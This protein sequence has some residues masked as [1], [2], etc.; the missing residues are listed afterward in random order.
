MGATGLA[1][2]TVLG[3]GRDGEQNVQEM[4]GNRPP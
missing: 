3:C 4:V 1:L 2:R